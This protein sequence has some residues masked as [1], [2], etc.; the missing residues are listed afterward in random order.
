LTLVTAFLFVGQSRAA[1]VLEFFQG[2][3]VNDTTLS[4]TPFSNNTVTLVPGGPTQFVQVA[5]HQTA[6]TNILTPTNGVNPFLIQGV[7]GPREPGNW[8][9]PEFVFG[10]QH[11]PICNVADTTYSLVH[12][13]RTGVNGSMS[14]GTETTATA[15]RFGGVTLNPPPSPSVDANGRFFIG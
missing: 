6:P 8:V 13:Y 14:G 9:V 4:L 5:M 12:A 3:S 11:V 10:S 7:S 15:F 1:I 2:T